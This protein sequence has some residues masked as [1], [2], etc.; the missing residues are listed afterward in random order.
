MNRLIRSLIVGCAVTAFTLSATGCGSE[1]GTPADESNTEADTSSGSEST[2]DVVERAPDD[3]SADDTGN[4]SGVERVADDAWASDPG[5]LDDTAVVPEEEPRQASDVHRQL[6]AGLADKVIVPTYKDFHTKAEALEAAAA[7]YKSSQSPS[8]FTALQDA[9][10]DAMTAWQYAEV[11]Q[12]GPA[13]SMTT[14]LGGEDLRS[15]IYSWPTINPCRV[16]QELTEDAHSDPQVFASE[17]VNARG[18]DALEYLLFKESDTNQ[19]KSTSKINKDGVWD[20]LVSSGEL[21]ARRAAYAHT[22]SV[23]IVAEAKALVDAWEGDGGFA[24]QLGGAGKT[25]TVYDSAQKAL[26]AISDAMFYAEKQTK[27]MKIAHPAG[28][29][30][31]DEATCPEMLEARWA[32]HSKE[33]VLA[34]FQALK[35]LFQ[36][37]PDAEADLG[38]DDVLTDMGASALAN[39]FNANLDTAIEMITASEMSFFEMLET[40]PDE[41]VNI[42]SAVKG[43][44]DLLK[45]EFMSTMDLEI[46]NRA[47]GDND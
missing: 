34:N 4:G 38:F 47:A 13:G 32:K 25:S 19:C 17:L 1:S 27:D 33:N 3:E 44:T 40:N 11:M 45:T 23:L 24:S 37:G 41:L 42:Y 16:D 28:I 9:W 30:T 15:E 8:D 20:D 39:D 46:P 35:W 5:P 22:L 10:R 31:C 36:G 6:L 43:V 21:P 29:S 14:A 12:V 2:A 7:A 26:N 18:L